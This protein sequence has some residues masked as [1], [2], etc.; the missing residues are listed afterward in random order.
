MKISFI[1]SGSVATHLGALFTSAGHDVAY[2]KRAPHEPSFSAAI[3][4][5]AIVV[6]AIPFTACQSVLPALA[7]AL[8][9]KIV[10]D[11]TNPLNADYSP[12]VLPGGRSAAEEIADLLPGSR[13]VKAFN[14]VF[15]DN[16]TADRIK[17]RDF[18]LAA[19]VAS[20]DETATTTVAQ[21]AAAIGFAPL[22]VRP[23][24]TAR[25]L[26]AMT[27]LLIAN[28]FGMGRGTDGAFI[29]ADAR[30]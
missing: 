28:A 21:L 24:R 5:A 11:A 30:S 2:G 25:Y 27:H 15:S 23:L 7:T 18:R 13:I 26:E 4:G 22:T 19:Y 6:I 16:M 1:G 9:G 8:N 20:D 12:L 29:F 10:I 14:S 3:N 17:R